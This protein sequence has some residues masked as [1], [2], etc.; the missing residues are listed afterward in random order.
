MYDPI[1]VSTALVSSGGDLLIELTDGTIINAGRVRG[2]PGPQ[3]ETGEQGIR[4]AHGKDGIDGTNG[5]KWH[6]GVGAPEI[7]LGEDGD[8]YMDVASA[9]LPI[10]QKV[11][12]DWLFLANLKVPPSG[13]GGGQGGAAGG[14]GSIIIFPPPNPGEQPIFD[15][16]GKPIQNGDLWYD[17]T[18]GHLWVYHNNQWTPIGDRPPVIISPDPPN[19]N[20]GSED[21]SVIKY[22]IAEGDLWFDSDQLALY[23]AAEDEAG[24]LRWVITTPADRSVLQD[25]VDIPDLPFRFPSPKTG[26][27]N[28]FDGM[29]VYNPVTKLWYVFNAGKNQWIDLPPGVNELS[30]TALLVRGPDGMD[31]SFAYRQEDRDRLGTDALCYVNADTHEDWTRMVI[32]NHDLTGFDWTLIT[33]AIIKGD[34]V[35]LIQF[36]KEDDPDLPDYTLRSDH[37]V[38]SNFTVVPPAGPFEAKNGSISFL[39]KEPPGDAPFFDEEVIIRFKAIVNTGE[40]EIYYQE[41]APDPITDPE[42]T[43]GNIWIDSDDN[44]LYVWNGTSWSEVTA[45]TGTEV[46]D[47]VLKAGDT[48]SGAL[49]MDNADH[50]HMVNTDLDFQPKS[51]DTGAGWD[52]NVDRFLDIESMSPKLVANDGTETNDHGDPFGINFDIDDGNTWKNRLKIS[53]RYGEIVTFFSGSGAQIKFGENQANGGFTPNLANTGLTSGIPILGIPT[54]DFDNSPGDIA[55]NKEYVDQRDEFLQNEIIELEEE[56]DALAPS[57]ERGKWTMNLTGIAANAGQMSLYDDDYSNVGNPTGLFADVKSIWLN[58]I[59][60]AGTPHGFAGV[61]AGEFIEL[62]VEGDPDY[63]LYQVVDIHDETNGAAQWWVIEVN[64]VRAYTPTSATAP[65]DIIRVKIFK[66]PEGGDASTFLNKY[67]DKVIDAVAN[68]DYE[69]NKPVTFETKEGAINFKT[70]SNQGVNAL[71]GR[72]FAVKTDLTTSSETAAFYVSSKKDSI[73]Y[74]SLFRVRAN[75]K[76]QA[77]PDDSDPFIATEDNDVTTKKYVDDKI[78]E[79]LAR[80]G[81]LEMAGGVPRNYHFEQVQVREGYNWTGYAN[82][83]WLWGD[84]WDQSSTQPGTSS[85]KL[86][87]QLPNNSDGSPRWLIKP[88]GHI[89]INDF[90]QYYDQRKV[91]SII[92]YPGK[93][94]V[95]EYRKSYGPQ[96]YYEITGDF[97]PTA[98][99]YSK[100]WSREAKV[101]MTF[102]GGS[103]EEVPTP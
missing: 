73:S 48:M 10:Y 20:S 102:V 31:G 88:Q 32:P 52:A 41:N 75:G 78:E 30:M 59:D 94:E 51:A 97:A 9:L 26:G 86:Q 6:T 11:G 21:G 1:S 81:E 15:N 85:R 55:V 54:P 96:T 76:V 64:F 42:L 74:K 24:D 45:C 23:V 69:W 3:G 19:F 93:I 34:Q 28:P 12:R 90:E 65:G 8:L 36:E 72:H 58:E 17:P 38:E 77:G 63:G 80:I 82:A 18:T 25:E 84:E 87:I 49:T 91:G 5:A 99:E 100:Y 13:G 53:N 98:S 103:V 71:T 60:N 62:F 33:T 40:D 44:K 70:P 14:G 61:E 68:V 4:G 92:F 43:A 89:I 56:L 16:D 27:G 35:S 66:A 101:R 47:Y 57:V 50:I 29:T 2:N 46:G 79:L 39:V 7:D 67:G 37:Q 95:K 22:P 83:F